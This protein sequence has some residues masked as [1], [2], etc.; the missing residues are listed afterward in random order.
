MM[1]TP[2]EANRASKLDALS[3]EIRTRRGELGSARQLNGAPPTNSQTAESKLQA[4][5]NRSQFLRAYN[6]SVSLT[7]RC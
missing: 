6:R 1:E 5:R 7:L 4:Y 3:D 2:P